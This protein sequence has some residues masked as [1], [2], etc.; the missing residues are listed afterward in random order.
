MTTTIQALIISGEGFGW[1]Y[2]RLKRWGYSQTD[3]AFLTY[4]GSDGKRWTGD[5]KLL[6]KLLSNPTMKKKES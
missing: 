1:G 4:F 5:V 2:H 6:V 3:L